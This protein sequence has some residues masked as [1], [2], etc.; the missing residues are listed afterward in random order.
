MQL[1]SD[2]KVIFVA[3]PKTGTRSIGA[4]LRNHFS[5]QPLGEHKQNIPK[6]YKEYFSF[7]VVRNPYDRICS[8]YWQRCH[9]DFDSWKCKDTFQKLGIDNTLENYLAVFEHSDSSWPMTKWIV[10]NDIDQI[11]RFETLEEDFNT[12]PFVKTFTKLPMLNASN[13]PPWEELVTTTARKRINKIF[14]NDF[15]LFNYE[16]IE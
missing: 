2:I 16:M 1:C 3:I 5:C 7:C 13:K 12:L 11:L 14:E 8:N 10:N 15:K 9:G 4:F 6:E